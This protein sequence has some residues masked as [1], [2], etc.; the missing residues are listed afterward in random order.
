MLSR[1]LYTLLTHIS[2]GVHTIIY[3]KIDI[4]MSEGLKSFHFLTCETHYICTKINNCINLFLAT[5]HKF[6]NC[7]CI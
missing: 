3:Y 4:R 7:N 2:V 6:R 5:I 1:A